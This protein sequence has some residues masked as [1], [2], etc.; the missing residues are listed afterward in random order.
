MP[1]SREQNAALAALEAMRNGRLDTEGG[2]PAVID[3]HTIPG[4]VL[5]ADHT[6]NNGPELTIYRWP[7]LLLWYR[8]ALAFLKD[9]PEDFDP[10]SPSCHWLIACGGGTAIV[11]AMYETETDD[12]AL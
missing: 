10:Q 8:R 4:Y 9:H 1:L 3:G 11:E 6:E 5:I 7:D 12:I 2:Y